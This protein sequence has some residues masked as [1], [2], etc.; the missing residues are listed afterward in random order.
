MLTNLSE[1]GEIQFLAD[2]QI[3]ILLLKMANKRLLRSE[4]GI[5]CQVAD[6]GTK[7]RVI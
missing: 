1:K 2:P 4:L 3:L 7:G 5:R 6:V